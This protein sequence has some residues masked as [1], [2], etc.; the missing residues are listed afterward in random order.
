MGNLHE[1]TGFGCRACWRLYVSAATVALL[2]SVLVLKSGSQW[3]GG[4]YPSRFRLHS[5]IY[6]PP[7]PALGGG[8]L[9][10]SASPQLRNCRSGSWAD[11]FV[12]LRAPSRA[13]S[14]A[15]PKIGVGLASLAL[16]FVACGENPASLPGQTGGS[17]GSLSTGGGSSQPAAGSAAI[18]D[19]GGMGGGAAA[20]S[21]GGNAGSMASAGLG[22]NAGSVAGAGSGGNAGSMASAGSG[23]TPAVTFTCAGTVPTQPTIT[24][25]DDL[26]AGRWQSPGDLGGGI[27]VY[28]QARAVAG[29]FLGF[30]GQV[31]DYAGAGVWFAGCFDASQYRG[32]RFSIHGKPGPTG[33]V[34]FSALTNRN[35][36]SSTQDYNGACLPA[37][38]AQPHQDCVAPSISV[39][40]SDVPTTHVVLWTELMGGKPSATTDGSDILSLQWSFTW[41]GSTDTPFDGRITVDDITFTDSTDDGAGGAS[42]DPDPAGG[43]GGV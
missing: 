6:P 1:P 27:Y 2:A 7:P 21:V 20:A 26:V 12:E 40:V 14:S 25:F 37:S 32:V 31:N 8:G 9:G 41:A 36:A 28:P 38:P 13:S 5:V 10:L 39:P 18:V 29:E 33:S 11:I 34:Q 42:P 19:T 16:V 17:A 15:M 35:K 22:G 23:G 24:S 3:S 43:A 30:D 4:S